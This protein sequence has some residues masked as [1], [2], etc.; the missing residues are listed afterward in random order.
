M[1]LIDTHALIWAMAD[2][3]KLS[4]AAKE[5]IKTSSNICISIASL[6]E[7]AIKQN[8]GKLNFSRTISEIATECQKHDIAILPI[9]PNHLDHI[10]TLPKIHGDPFDRLL[11]AQAETEN[12]TIIT[13]DSIIP[14]YGI[15]T[16]W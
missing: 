6:W 1:F 11:I 10:K 14:K 16:I 5:A 12:L 15:P 4:L 8:I 2:E 7:I 9:M 13:K 3:N